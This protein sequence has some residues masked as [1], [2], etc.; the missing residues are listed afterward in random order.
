MKKHLE[1]KLYLLILFAVAYSC[2][3][4][5]IVSYT[6]AMKN[7]GIAYDKKWN[8]NFVAL[9]DSAMNFWSNYFADSFNPELKNASVEELAKIKK[10][11]VQTYKLYIEEIKD[12]TISQPIK[13]YMI[14]CKDS[15]CLYVFP[16]EGKDSWQLQMHYKNGKW[17]MYRHC[18][19][20]ATLGQ[21]EE[22]NENKKLPLFHLDV[23]SKTGYRSQY[24]VYINKQNQV[25]SV[26]AHEK[27][28]LLDDVLRE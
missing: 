28:Q 4:I 25:M 15:A 6:K 8:N 9:S 10:L 16:K 11:F 7:S 20:Y 17:K 12:D 22:I 21:I 5:D 18:A 19:L 14:P 27:D 23:I 24:L 26:R 1:K 13:K 2:K 3:S